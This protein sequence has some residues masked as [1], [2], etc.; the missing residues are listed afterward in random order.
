MTENDWKEIYFAQLLEFVSSSE[1]ELQRT[2]EDARCL[3]LMYADLYETEGEER[4]AMCIRWLGDN[5]KLPC[6]FHRGEIDEWDW[7]IFVGEEEGVHRQVADIPL[8][9]FLAIQAGG[10]RYP[11]GD[12]RRFPNWA[13]IRRCA[14]SPFPVC[15]QQKR[16]CTGFGHQRRL[17]ITMTEQDWLVSDKPQEMLRFLT[18]NIAVQWEVGE[19]PPTLQSRRPSDRRLRLFAVGYT[20]LSHPNGHWEGSEHHDKAVYEYAE[21][22]AEGKSPI[23]IMDYTPYCQGLA[24]L[25]HDS[26]EQC[27]IE[28]ASYTLDGWSSKQEADVLRDVVGNP[29]RPLRLLRKSL[30]D[31]GRCSCSCA[32]KCPLGRGGSQL[33]CTTGELKHNNV[34][35]AG[36]WLTPEVLSLAEAA[37]EE[38]SGRKCEKCV[39]GWISCVS[40]GIKCPDCH[41]I[42][43]IEDG[44]LDNDRLGVLSDVLEEAGCPVEEPCPIDHEWKGVKIRDGFD[45]V[46]AMIDWDKRQKECR[47][48]GTGRLPNPLLAHLRSPGPHVRG[49]HVLD[50]LLGKE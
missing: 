46:Q 45:A 9:L 25:V 1:D 8:R 48:K 43:R 40:A 31:D 39:G 29:F 33:R 19:A 7:W 34:V 36:E 13:E 44:T 37:Y 14:T 50:A 12:L 16:R 15:E 6:V 10:D 5:N 18:Q 11:D 2:L 17:R 26:A 20:R 22:L 32:D 35:L 30:A 23:N 3:R 4:I 28:V 47:C 41:G 27:A 24:S 42:G 38:R 49:C 21:Q